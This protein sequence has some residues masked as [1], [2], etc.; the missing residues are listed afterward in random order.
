[1]RLLRVF[2]QRERCFLSSLLGGEEGGS[3]VEGLR[4][5]AEFRNAG[6]DSK[7]KMGSGGW[8]ETC[9]GKGPFKE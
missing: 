2:S 6:T 9:L 1:M 3:T 8:I 5:I 7:R 4:A